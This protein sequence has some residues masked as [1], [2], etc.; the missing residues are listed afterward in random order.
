[1]CKLLIKFPTR[2]RVEKF[3][4]ILELY[5]S[6]LE[7]PNNTFFVI[8]CDIDDDDMNNE[9]VRNRLRQYKNLQV[10]FANNKSKVEAINNNIGDVDFDILLLAS[11]DM[12]PQVFGFDTVVRSKMSEIF[13][14]FDGVLWFNDGYQGS[15]INTLSILGKK[16]YDRFG[17]IYHPSYKS[18]MCDIEF[19][20]VS[21]KLNKVCYID[22]VII[23]HEHLVWTGEKYDALQIHN[24]SFL[25]EDG[26]NFSFRKENG[27]QI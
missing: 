23:R 3:F 8:S 21:K 6:N 9:F 2:G 10:Y 13:P 15:N 20:E 19:M 14:D 12:I 26:L 27:F 22:N 4:K 16:Y 7:D 18:L 11:D 5:Y 24:D 25:N 1:M 17:Y